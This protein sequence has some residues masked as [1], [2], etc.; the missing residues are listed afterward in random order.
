[1]KGRPAVD[2]AAGGL[3]HS[4][5]SVAAEMSTPPDASGSATPPLG[6]GSSPSAERAGFAL[7]CG[8]P[9]VAYLV[10]LSGHS[11]WLDA[12]EFVAVAAD[13]GIAHPP[14]HPLFAVY[15]KLWSLLP[16]GALP[17][18]IALGQALAAALAAGLLYRA[19]LSTASALGAGRDW[20][21]KI[22][23]LACAWLW[24]LSF[25]VWFQAVRPE[26]YALQALVL[27]L[28]IERM[29]ALQLDP[30]RGTRALYAATFA[31]RVVDIFSIHITNCGSVFVRH[32]LR[33][34]LPS[35]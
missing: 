24:S 21:A 25:G 32:L 16:L 5:P 33:R 13:L 17:F 27:L 29:V 6:S 19:C 26:V 12:G 35:I 20:P 34:I 31:D 9:F 15:G 28:A 2:A 18:R 11:Y 3:G 7:A 10:T 22:T 14:G 1:M 30:A 23:A 4:T 8:L